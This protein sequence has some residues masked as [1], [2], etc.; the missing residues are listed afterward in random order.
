M[1]IRLAC[2]LSLLCCV[3]FSCNREDEPESNSLSKEKKTFDVSGVKF[4]MI[5]VEGDT[6]TMGADTAMDADYWGDEV[7]VHKVILSDYYIGELEVTQALWKKVVG[8][9]PS[10]NYKGGSVSDKYP[11]ESVSWNDCQ[12]FI[13]KLNEMTKRNFALPTEAQWEF[14]AK[15]GKK[16]LSYKF[17]GGDGMKIVGWCTDNSEKETH[18]TGKKKPNELGLYDMSGNV[19]E[20][21]VDVYGDYDTTM[22][23]NPTGPAISNSVA[24]ERVARGGSFDDPAFY[25]R[26]SFRTKSLPT[27]KLKYVGLRLVLKAEDAY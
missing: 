3:A 26:N 11:V 8:T 20:W 6:F 4:N 25:C 13:T 27:S 9:V 16:S 21:C 1:K 2:I 12:K 5:L 15:G 22:Q 17:S 19:R 18:E 24:T 14:A 7:P 23:I 10:D